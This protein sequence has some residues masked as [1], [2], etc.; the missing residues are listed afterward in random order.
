MD[1]TDEFYINHFHN[2]Q[3]TE[4]VIRHYAALLGFHVSDGYIESK[5][6]ILQPCMEID[7][8]HS[9][10]EFLESIIKTKNKHISIKK[11]IFDESTFIRETF[12]DELNEDQI[13]RL[14][15]RLKPFFRHYKNKVCE[16]TIYC[17][18]GHK[19]YSKTLKVCWYKDFECVLNSILKELKQEKTDNSYLFT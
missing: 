10:M 2:P 18:E 12:F 11:D 16:L 1:K 19:I 6:G 5:N 13:E 17:A 3:D 8:K 14:R 15:E 7:K 4:M 9:W